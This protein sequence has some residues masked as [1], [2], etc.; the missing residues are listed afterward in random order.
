MGCRFCG[1]ACKTY[2]PEF[3]Y[4]AASTVYAP[5]GSTVMVPSMCGCIRQSYS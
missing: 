2:N 4:V 1:H 3:P 5:V